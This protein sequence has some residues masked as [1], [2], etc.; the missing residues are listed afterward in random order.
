MR[1]IFLLT[2]LSALLAGCAAPQTRALLSSESTD[3]PQRALLSDTP[4]IAQEDF[5]CGPSSLAMVMN[6]Y[7]LEVTAEDL[8]KQVYIPGLKGSLLAEMSAATRS[9]DLLAYELTPSMESLLREIA[10]E[11]P[12]IVLQNLGVSWYPVWHYAVAIGYDLESKEIILHSGSREEYHVALSVFERTWQRGNSWALVP[13]PPNDL[14]HD[15]NAVQLIKA[16]QALEETGHVEPAYLAYHAA[17]Q[18]WPENIAAVMGTG[19]TFYALGKYSQ[20]S[21]SFRQATELDP[22]SGAAYNNLA[23][24]LLAESCLQAAQTS[25]ECA[26]TINDTFSAEYAKTLAE[27]KATAV[28]DSSDP[29]HCPTINCPGGNK[30]TP[31]NQ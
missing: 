1:R 29:T 13:L 15:D 7:G 11:H 3:L 6:Y 2:I 14:P 27:V 25:A 9:H 21:E 18:R 22:L 8:A 28:Q 30:K 5:Y 4:F 26:I 12:V 31:S 10:D 16:A 17:S 19:N 24:S 23:V 20:A